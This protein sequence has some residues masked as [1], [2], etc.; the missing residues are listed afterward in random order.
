[1]Q[2]V[3]TRIRP[4]VPTN[5]NIAADAPFSGEFDVRL[6]EVLTRVASRVTAE[7]QLVA[8]GAVAPGTRRFDVFESQERFLFWLEAQA[9]APEPVVRWDERYSV[10]DYLFLGGVIQNGAFER[11][12]CLTCEATFA[13]SQTMVEEWKDEAFEGGFKVLCPCGHVLAKTIEW[14]NA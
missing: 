4:R 2:P 3:L 6:S 14:I 7:R 8:A 13:P 9:S 5:A 10:F 12:S 11:V 1:M